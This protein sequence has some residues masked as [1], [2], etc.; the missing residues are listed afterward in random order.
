MVY[1]CRVC[2]SSDN[3]MFDQI[4]SFYSSLDTVAVYVLIKN[5]NISI[6]WYLTAEETQDDNHCTAI[7]STFD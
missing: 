3:A 2:T 6:F 4:K 1:L 7:L 5:I